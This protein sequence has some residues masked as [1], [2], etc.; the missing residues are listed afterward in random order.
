MGERNGSWDGLF[1]GKVCHQL[2]D[3]VADVRQ[4]L[5][6]SGDLCTLVQRVSHISR[7]YPKGTPKSSIRLVVPR[8]SIV[9]FV[10]RTPSGPP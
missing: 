3:R 10:E 1:I 7:Y 6:T 5:Y 9:L 8:M 2:S 4:P